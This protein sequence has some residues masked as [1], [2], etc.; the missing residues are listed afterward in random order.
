MG[1]LNK[2]RRKWFE[3][4]GPQGRGEVDSVALTGKIEL[5]DEVVVPR[6]CCLDGLA[7]F[8]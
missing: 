2:G 6:L 4:V 5:S 1:G 8:D 3:R 7:D